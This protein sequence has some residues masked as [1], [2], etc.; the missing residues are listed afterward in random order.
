[1][2][3]PDPRLGQLIDG[4]YRI[5]S[6]LGRGQTACVYVAEQISMKRQ[7]AL[8]IL[9]DELRADRNALARVKREVDAVVR[10]RSPHAIT[11]FDFGYSDTDGFYIAM[12]LLQ[13][14]SLRASLR[15]ERVVPP[16]LVLSIATQVGSCLA[17]AHVAGV[18]HRDLKPENIFLCPPQRSGDRPFVKVLDFG[19]A[20]LVHP[21]LDASAQVL[22]A[23]RTAIGTPAYLAPEMAR[24][25]RTPD[26]RVDLYSLGLIVFEMLAGRRAF[27]ATSPGAMLYEQAFEK[28][29]RISALRAELPAALDDFFDTALAKDPDRRF[30]SADL[31]VQALTRVL[32]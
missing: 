22:T 26:H 14:E 7:V 28:A 23:P 32:A 4:R 25:G 19:L 12:E 6:F 16:A 11:F 17:E 3:A 8:K 31:F 10:L 2:D 9:H 30:P 27:V 15:R 20:K 18:I 29:P 1:M 13:G 21:D 24:A 5:E